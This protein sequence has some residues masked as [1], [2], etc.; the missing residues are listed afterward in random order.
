MFKKYT[1]LSLLALILSGSFQ[2]LEAIRFSGGQFESSDNSAGSAFEVDGP[3]VVWVNGAYQWFYQNGEATRLDLYIQVISGR[4]VEVVLAEVF[5]DSTN[6]TEVS[7][8]TRLINENHPCLGFVATEDEV[9]RVELGEG[10]SDFDSNLNEDC[11][12]DIYAVSLEPEEIAEF[13]FGEIPDEFSVGL[14]L[15][16]SGVAV[17]LTAGVLVGDPGSKLNEPAEDVGATQ[18]LTQE[19]NG[20]GCVAQPAQ[21][22]KLAI[23]LMLLALVLMAFGAR[24]SREG[25]RS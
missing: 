16:V 1:G 21:S 23:V 5:D 25:R 2:P 20:S 15:I 18:L 24:T 4:S 9:E 12:G 11:A 19:L 22:N 14:S 10:L 3:Q 6:P 7:F 8:R 17:D 13:F